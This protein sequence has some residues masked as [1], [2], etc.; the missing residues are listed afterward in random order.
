MNEFDQIGDE[1]ER[2]IFELILPLQTTKEIKEAAFN[3]ADEAGRTLARLLKGHE[4]LPRKIIYAL[5]MAA[6]TLENEA[7]Y[8]HDEQKVLAMSRAFRFTFGLILLG[9]SHEDRKPG[10]ARVR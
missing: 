10:V 3:A 2:H 9:E 7:P 8:S 5:D 1:L 4:M 6:G